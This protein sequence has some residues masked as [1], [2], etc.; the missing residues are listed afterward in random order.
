MVDNQRRRGGPLLAA[1]TGGGDDGITSA[2]RWADW[3]G[4]GGTF[5]P[6]K[7]KLHL[8]NI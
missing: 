3:V 6:G 1:A 4:G 8:Y 7:H 5:G 2:L